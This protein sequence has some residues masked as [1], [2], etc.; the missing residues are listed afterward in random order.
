M[1]LASSA[2][3]MG[4]GNAGVHLCH[5]M[6]YPVSSQ[7]KESFSGHAASYQTVDHALIPHGLSVIVNAPAVF[8]WTASACPERHATVARILQEARRHR[9]GNGTSVKSQQ[10]GSFSSDPGAWLA[11]EIRDL[12]QTLGVSTGLQQFGYTAAD[13]TSLVDGTIQQ[14]RVT[15]ISPRKVERQDLEELFATALQE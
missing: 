7:V 8:S 6:S 5:G 11:D 4:F 9:E 10:N 2:A 1:L 14:H 12:C 3:G 13:I 15:K